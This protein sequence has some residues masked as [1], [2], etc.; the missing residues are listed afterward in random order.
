MLAV[1]TM[2]PVLGTHSSQRCGPAFCRDDRECCLRG[3]ASSCCNPLE[4][5]TYYHVAM[6]TRKL[7]GVLIMLLL[8]ALGYFIQRVLCSR[9]RQ[10]S[11]DNGGD[12]TVTTSRELLVELATPESLL[13]GRS[14]AHLPTYDQCKRLPTYEETVRY[15]QS[16]SSVGQST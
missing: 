7:S 12:P 15:G 10:L 9:S 4:D 1:L 13:D 2:C 8:F 5:D 11:S 16:Q 6:A 3:N 14:A